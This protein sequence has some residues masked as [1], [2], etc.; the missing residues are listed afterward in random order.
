MPSTS[1]FLIF[2][3]IESNLII[4]IV[5]A[6]VPPPSRTTK[7]QTKHDGMTIVIY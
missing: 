4:F 2:L 5:K 1:D 3:N 6:K 7:R